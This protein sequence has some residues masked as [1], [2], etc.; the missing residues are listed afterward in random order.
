VVMVTRRCSQSQFLMR[1]DG[2]TNN[3]FLYC[4]ALSARKCEVQ[5]IFFL[6][7]SDHY[8]AGLVNTAGR[9]PEFLE[10]FHRL[11]SKHQNV[12]RGRWEN[13]WS[14][15]Q[16][17]VVEL[18]GAEDVLEKTVCTLTNPVASGG[19]IRPQEGGEICPQGRG[20][21][22]TRSGCDK[23]GGGCSVRRWRREGV[24]RQG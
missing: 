8:H 2:D 19:V 21:I 24:A 12:L 23:G 18:V 22:A 6:A 9:L 13:F 10:E 5:V 16:T 11:F 1:P 3:A 4:L 14:S 7:M 20:W 17:S 15:E